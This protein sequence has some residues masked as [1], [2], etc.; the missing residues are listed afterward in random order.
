MQQQY[1]HPAYVDVSH[2]RAPY[3]NAYLGAV[4]APPPPGPAGELGAGNP[5]LEKRDGM[6]FWKAEAKALAMATLRGLR[7]VRIGG[8]NQIEVSPFTA[9]ELAAAAADP[10]AAD[11]LTALSAHAWVEQS[12]AAGNVVVAPIWLFMTGT[13]FDKVLFAIPAGNTDEVKEAAST[14]MV[15]IL[16]GTPRNPLLMAGIG[17]GVLALGGIAVY[18]VYKMSKKGGRQAASPFK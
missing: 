2:F 12:V 10:A 16:A 13:T 8:E 6:Y 14:E 3:K 11:Y 18:A 17:V 9:E 15:G 1:T 7:A 4:D 5:F